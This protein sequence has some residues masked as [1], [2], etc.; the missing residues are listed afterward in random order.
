MA[1]NKLGGGAK[2]A[3]AATKGAAAPAKKDEKKEAPVV[4]DLSN[5]KKSYADLE[6]QA[7]ARTATGVK[8][9]DMLTVV[10]DL[11]KE[12]GKDK[13]LFSGVATIVKAK[14]GNKKLYNQLRSAI[15]AKTSDYDLST[16]ADGH[17]YVVKGK[18][19]PPAEAP[20]E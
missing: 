17:A 11:F 16:E 13:L 12:T 20:A 5:L 19:N 15:L 6:A 4:V 9:S 18:K 2:N 8:A 7:K 10:G 1:I 14:F 3:P